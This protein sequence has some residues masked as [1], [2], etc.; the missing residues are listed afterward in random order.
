MNQKLSKIFDGFGEDFID[1][2]NAFSLQILFVNAIKRGMSD[3]GITQK[4][5]SIKLGV[6]P[7][8]SDGCYPN[9]ENDF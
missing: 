8:F 5:L 2:I 9:S 3:I 7:S 6:T 4:E 1:E